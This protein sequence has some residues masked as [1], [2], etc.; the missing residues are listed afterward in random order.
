MKTITVNIDEETWSRAQQKA[1]ALETSVSQVVVEYLRQWANGDAI[2][3]ARNA[4][5]ERFAQPGSRFAIGTPDDREQ[6]NARS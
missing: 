6:R 5:T 4:M 1:V 3:R 2:Q